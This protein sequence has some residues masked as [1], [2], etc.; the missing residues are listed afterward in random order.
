MKQ[1]HDDGNEAKTSTMQHKCFNDA[2]HFAHKN[3]YK[4]KA[5]MECNVQ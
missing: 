5:L 3:H 4:Q 1:E 2:T